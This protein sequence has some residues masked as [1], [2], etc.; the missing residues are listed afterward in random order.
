MRL[1][2]DLE[3]LFEKGYRDIYWDDV[4]IFIYPN[5]YKLKIYKMDRRDVVEIDSL[6][7]LS[8]IDKSYKKNYRMIK[9]VCD[10]YGKRK[11]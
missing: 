7:E 10:N 4:V 5:H 8:E 3:E 2:Q 6:E 11:E 9:R 1:K